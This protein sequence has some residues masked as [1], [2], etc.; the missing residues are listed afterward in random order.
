MKIFVECEC[1]LLQASLDIFLKDYLAPKEEAD[2]VVCDTLLLCQKPTFC[3]GSD[4]SLPFT[5]AQLLARLDDFV[6]KN[7][8]NLRSI[9]AGLDEILARFKTDLI[10]LFRHAR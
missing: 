9:E 6:R 5:S 7:T 3:I 1:E 8:L 2:F 10:E 4:I